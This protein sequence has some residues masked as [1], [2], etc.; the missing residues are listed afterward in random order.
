MI[1]S[2]WRYAD[3]NISSSWKEQLPH[4]HD[5][6]WINDFVSPKWLNMRCF[7]L[8]NKQKRQCIKSYHL[9]KVSFK[10][11]ELAGI[12]SSQSKFIRIRCRSPV[13][14]STRITQIQFSQALHRSIYAA[15]LS[16]LLN[17]WWNISTYYNWYLN[18]FPV[19]FQLKTLRRPDGN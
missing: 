7:F 13:T 12:Q 16:S 4:L 3:E 6:Q 11:Q 10:N 9:H 8:M 1:Q 19:C 5:L 18:L 14:S 2:Q 17:Q 15:E